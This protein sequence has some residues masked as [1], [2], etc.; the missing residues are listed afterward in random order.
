[1]EDNKKLLTIIVPVYKVKDYLRK[2]VD[3]ILAQTYKNF[4]LILVDDGSPDECGAICDSYREIDKRVKVIHKTNGGL[5]SARNA[6]LEIA[7]GKYIGYVD[8]DDWIEPTMY[9]DMIR[10]LEDND[11]Q[12]VEC[13]INV[14]SGNEIKKVPEEGVEIISGRDALI[15]HLDTIHIYSMPRPSV[16]SKLYK[17]EFWLENRF[18]EGK[19]HEDYLLTCMALY[20]SGEVGLLHKGLYNH[21]VDNSGSI[22]NA[23]FSKRDLFRGTQYQYIVD[24]LSTK[25]DKI[26]HDMA[27]VNYFC[28]MV[29]AIWKCDQNGLRNEVKEYINIVQNH[30]DQIR[31]LSFSWKKKFDL[32]LIINSPSLFLVFRRVLSSLRH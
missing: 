16:W 25:N 2:C 31:H 19:I 1:M 11:C 6:G 9:E 12:M 32:F 5:S 18:P 8:S 23:K 14:V 15:R 28:Y 7:N 24:Y 20:E 26:L 13:A 21:L 29:T 27:K 4:E 30:K 22:C 3:S 10:V 17:R